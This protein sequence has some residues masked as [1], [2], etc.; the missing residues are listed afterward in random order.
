M[1]ETIDIQT[2]TSQIFN[3]P[4]W[5]R[6]WIYQSNRPFTEKEMVVLNSQ[7]NAFVQS[8]A[9]HS[10]QLYA[11]CSIVHNQFIILAVDEK[12]AGASGC[13]IDKSVHFMQDIENQYGISLF[14]RMTFA[15]MDNDTVKTASKPTFKRF[16]TEGVIN[17]ET[18]VFDNL[19]N[20]VKDLKSTWVKPLKE[21]WHRRFV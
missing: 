14:D 16:Y 4:D 19:V 21:S 2:V 17:D 1:S 9:A 6:V 20:T 7:L 13:S 5:S 8:W 18:P 15:Y 3:L 12:Q 11:A 10:Q